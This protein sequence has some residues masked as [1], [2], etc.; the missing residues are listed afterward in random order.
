MAARSPRRR[1]PP[2]LWRCLGRTN[3]RRTATLCFGFA[4]LLGAGLHFKPG[5]VATEGTARQPN[6]SVGLPESPETAW[7]GLSADELVARFSETRVGQVVFAT[8]DTDSCPRL[9]FD[10]RTGTFYEAGEV[11]C[12]LSAEPAPPASDRMLGIQKAFQR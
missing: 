1:V 4:V 12:G 7:R 9:L 10:N 2:T 3:V 8:M 6:G 5:P 11:Y